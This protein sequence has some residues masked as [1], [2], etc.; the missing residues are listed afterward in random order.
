MRGSDRIASRRAL[1]LGAGASLGASLV[2]SCARAA[3]DAYAG[4]PFRKISEAEWKK[5]LPPKAFAILRKED[6]E[7]PGS[8]PLLNEKRTGTYH[9]LGC[10]LPLFRSAWKY[11]S[12]TGWPSFH[13]ALPGA[14]GLKTD[15]LIGV[16][17]TE[18]HCA[19]CLGHHGHRFDDG[20]RPTRLRYCS[21][22]F[23]L[24]F[25]PA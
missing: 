10:D 20:P 13:T 22:G 12:G 19:R 2:V 1:L 9:C 6:T 21:N 25:Q 23:A 17:R 5:R 8:S 11:D 18:Y 24:R 3:S 15:W 4:S 16:P 7:P 14:L